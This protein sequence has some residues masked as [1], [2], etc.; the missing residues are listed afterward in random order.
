M[1]PLTVHDVF[2]V[3]CSHTHIYA[4][5]KVSRENYIPNLGKHTCS[6]KG[7]TGTQVQK[8]S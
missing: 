1:M 7:T 8:V 2:T 4:C 6:Q 5:V 3:I